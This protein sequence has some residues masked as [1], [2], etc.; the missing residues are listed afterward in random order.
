[1]ARGFIIEGA[2][3]LAIG[4]VGGAGIGWAGGA[5]NGSAIAQSG[6]L[7]GGGTVA[8]PGA[9]ARERSEARAP[10]AARSHASRAAP[11]G[12]GAEAEV[13]ALMEGCID[14]YGGRDMDPVLRR[15]VSQST[16]LGIR[17]AKS[18][19]MGAMLG[20]NSSLHEMAAELEREV[21]SM[22]PERQARFAK[23]SEEI[24]AKV[25]KI[26]ECAIAQMPA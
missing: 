3:V 25:P 9:V 1:M 17:M 19:D 21:A 23:Q 4:L 18:G 15:H 10:A 2:L 14:R 22:S 16:K 6:T 12:R 20:P 5:F 7:M 8:H 11:T 24:Q 13:L 26:L